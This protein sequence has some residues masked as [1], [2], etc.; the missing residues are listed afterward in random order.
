LNFRLLAAEACGARAGSLETPRGTIPT[1]HFMPV[2]TQA[3]VKTLSPQDLSAVG[4]GIVLAN[5]FHLYLRPGTE[6]VRK[7]GGL[8]R[9]MGW[10]GPLLTD[11]GGFQVFS[12]PEL[13]KVDD[14]G[15]TFASPLDGSKHRFTP[16]SVIDIELALGADIVMAFDECPPYPCS[17]EV[18]FKALE[19]TSRWAARCQARMAE[20]EGQATLFGIVQGGVFPEQRRL[21]ARQ[22]T[23][24]GFEGYALGGLSVG[25]P[26]ALM[27]ST[28]EATAPL[29]PSDKPRYL[30]GVGTPEDLWECVQRGMDL[31]DCVM[32]TRVARNGTLFTSGGRL[33]VKNASFAQ[34]FG[35]LDPECACYACRNFSRAYL[36][37]LYHAGEILGLRLGSLHN[38]TFMMKVCGLIRSAIL[39]GRF[40]DAKAEFLLQYGA[41]KKDQL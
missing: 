33:S 41:A 27:H 4:A 39:E 2:G 17:E 24:L 36:R 40:L 28:L 5:S 8:H 26:K 32:P 18:S 23:D 14:E 37:H 25:E 29:L 34:D 13:R 31:F 7:A 9:F 10:D 12:L 15:V 20:R 38:L 3:T 30:M 11:S 35:P 21:S 6:V 22:V 16:E 19:R 1:P